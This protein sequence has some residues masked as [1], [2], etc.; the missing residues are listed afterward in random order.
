MRDSLSS[1]ITVPIAQDFLEVG[2][3]PGLLLMLF[4]LVEISKSLLS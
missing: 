4:L 1:D 3:S 2:C